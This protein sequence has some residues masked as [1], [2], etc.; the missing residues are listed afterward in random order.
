MSDAHKVIATAGIISVGIG[1]A[2]SVLKHKRPPSSKFLI[3]SGA[4]YLILSALADVEPEVAKG[5]AMGVATTVV[6]GEGGGV[7][8]YINGGEMDT[9]PKK[10]PQKPQPK[11]RPQRT[12]QPR[13][14]VRTVKPE[15][16]YRGDTPT[17]IPGVVIN[18]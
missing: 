2:N 11:P 4:A 18:P 9:A 13:V 16:G 15:N 3:G 5:L 7:L 17:P 14:T 8:E 6:L 1:S 10:K 12:T